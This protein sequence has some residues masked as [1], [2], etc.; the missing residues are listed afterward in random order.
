M[1]PENTFFYVKRFIGSKVN[2]LDP[3]LLD[4]PYKLTTDEDSNILIE[5]PLIKKTLRP[6]EI[7]AQVLKK[8]AKDAT[9]YL[10]QE[11]DKAV[12][13]VPAYFNGSQRQATQDAGRI[14]GLEIL[15]IINEPTAASLAYGLEKNTDEVILVYDLGGGTFDVSILEVGDGIFEVLATSGDTRLGGSDFDNAILEYLIDGFNREYDLD[16]RTDTLALQRLS[17]TAEKTKIALTSSTVAKVSLPFITAT[18]TGPK[19]LH[20]D[21]TR[22]TFDEFSKH[23]VERCNLPVETALVDAGLSRDNVQQVVLVGG[24]TRIPSIRNSVKTLFPSSQLHLSV[25]PDEVVAV[26]AAIQASIISGEIKEILLLDVTPLSLG[27]ETLGGLVARMIPRNTTIPT[28]TSEI[29]STASDYQRTVEIAILQGERE[30][31][32]DNKNL[33]TFSLTGI[34]P[35]PRGESQIEVT[36]DI[37]VN[38]ILSVTATDKGTGKEQSVTV[39]GTSNLK[40]EEIEAIILNAEAYADVDR[41]NRYLIQFKNDIERAFY[42]LETLSSNSSIK[43]PDSIVQ[44]VGKISS[45]G[46]TL[47]ERLLLNKTAELVPIME[48]FIMQIYLFKNKKFYE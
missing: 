28:R 17:E 21:L 44:G 18:S 15:R 41:I 47:T 37:D 35:A 19:H 45:Y 34:E 27:I 26:G 38:G 33:G 46:L 9:A 42:G 6:E 48:A 5:C 8:L 4:M 39:S 16:V 2:E 29:F 12:I 1:N 20:R 23:I 32:R 40:Q 25:N 13:T 22:E 36:F 31:A 30:F 11:V 24:A 10:E 7:S 43:L 3:D 14:A